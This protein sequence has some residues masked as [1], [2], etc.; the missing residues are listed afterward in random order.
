[1]AENDLHHSSDGGNFRRSRYFSDD[2]FRDADIVFVDVGQG[3]C[4]HMRVSRSA[5]SDSFPWIGEYNVLI[6]GG[7]KAGYD[8]GKKVLK[9]YLLKNGVYGI[10]LAI[11][12]HL[13]TDHYEGIRSLCRD[14]M[15]RKLCVYEGYRVE[16][17]RI[18]SEC[19]LDKKDLMYVT[20]GDVIKVG[21][22]GFYIL[23]PEK[24]S[25][26]EYMRLS[27]DQED[28]NKKSLLIKSDY[29]GISTLM[30]GDIGTEGE[31]EVMKRMETG[32]DTAGDLNKLKCHIL[33][34]GHHGSRYS[35]GEK[36]LDA[37]DPGFAVI[38]VGKNNYGHPAEEILEK[39]EKRG[40]GV[41]RTDRNGAVGIDIKDN[42]AEA[43]VMIKN[44]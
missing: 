24:R 26:E 30:T 39:L 28:E 13:H 8:V 38:Q 33:K 37:A 18:L 4:M 25:D 1:M 31:D 6:D 34:V 15:V 9:P 16:E 2:K 17:K 14:G 32:K 3:D 12:T 11:V 40:I 35:T 43:D 27:E 23:A 41:Y 44:W 21:Q 19:G 22:A 42:R 10:D 29:K 7:G 5:G 20:E 36:F